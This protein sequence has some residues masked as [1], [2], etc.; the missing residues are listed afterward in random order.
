MANA[1]LDDYYSLNGGRATYV[2]IPFIFHTFFLCHSKN[3]GYESVVE[4][5]KKESCCDEVDLIRINRQE[6]FMDEVMN[7]LENYF[8]NLKSKGEK[9]PRWKRKMRPNFSAISAASGI[10]FEYLTK[11]PYQNR[12]TLAVQELGFGPGQPFRPLRNRKLFSSNTEKLSNYLKHLTDRGLK[13]PENPKQPGEIY[14]DQ[15]ESEAGLNKGALSLNG[16]EIDSTYSLRLRDLLLNASKSLGVEVRILLSPLDGSEDQITYDTLK[17]SGTKERK[18]ELEKSPHSDQQLYNTRWALNL[19]CQTLSLVKTAP[20]GNELVI[21]FIPAVE[22]ITESIRNTGTRKKFQTEI[23]WWHNFY[24]RLVNGQPLPEEFRAAFVYLID[25]SGLSRTVLSNVIGVNRPSLQSWYNGSQTPGA[26]SLMHLSRMETLFKV[27]AGTLTNKISRGD[28]K[29][30]FYRSQ[31]PVYLQGKENRTLYC[32]VAPHLPDNFPELQAEEQD[33]IVDSIR[34]N[35]LRCDQPSTLRTMELQRLPYRLK[36]WPG[37]LQQ[38]FDGLAAFKMGLMP[39]LGMDRNG[40][41]RPE[42][43]EKKHLDLS[44]WFGALLLPPD[45][46]DERLCGLGVMKEN[47]TLALMICPLLVDWYVRFRGEI[48]SQYTESLVTF[49]KECKGLLLPGTG[50]IRQKP[51]LAKQLHPIFSGEIQ[52]IAEEYISRALSDWGAVCEEAIIKYEALIKNLKGLVTVSRDPFF[53]IEGITDRDNPMEAIELLVQSLIINRPNPH[54]A[55]MHYHTNIRNCVLI[56]L[57]AVTGLRRNTVAQLDY[58]GG[59]TGHLYLQGTDY[60]LKIPRHLFKE[61]NSPFFGPKHA[62]SD[63]YMILPDVFGLYKILTEYLEVSRTWLLSKYHQDCKDDPLFVGTAGSV[64]ARLRPDNI[65]RVYN[66]ATALYLVENEWRG[67]GLKK[68]GRSGCHSVR[69]IRGSSVVKKTGSIE[70]AADANHNSPQMARQHYT[71]FLPK[72]RNKR[73]N[74]I[75]FTE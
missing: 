56:L 45:N 43:K 22:K 19:F 3:Y 49:V 37:Q 39:P 27:P 64:T 38:E 57:I 75:L 74:N 53:R 54:T 6:T 33:K 30:R 59:I 71:R 40:K 11:E 67:T 73:V 58:T 31:L 46:Q 51:Q 69:H 23:H 17:K 68:V 21:N 28:R 70:L 24:Q 18:Q 61:E 35:I 62:Q 50:W 47:L 66:Q 72:D 55:P 12:I 2:S 16:R 65:S 34:T 36:E 25:K 63:Y 8:E 60:V 41:W 26:Q 13:L 10:D 4:N 1:L 20:V 42:T 32:R 7:K 29:R 48:R 9:V 15:V 44:Y 52:F 5:Q 14:F